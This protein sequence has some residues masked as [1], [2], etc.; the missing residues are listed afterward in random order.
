MCAIKIKNG[1][2]I[3]HPCQTTKISKDYINTKVG[4]DRPVSW[5]PSFQTQR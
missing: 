4:P 1:V 5:V 2:L 3:K